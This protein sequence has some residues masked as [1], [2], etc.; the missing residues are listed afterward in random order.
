MK[1]IF[2][3]IPVVLVACGGS[4]TDSPAGTW[5]GY[6]ELDTPTNADVTKWNFT[7]ELAQPDE[8]DLYLGWERLVGT[9]DIAGGDYSAEGL[10][11]EDA[12]YSFSWCQAK[13]G[14]GDP[15]ESDF[16]LWQYGEV[17]F[18]L[19]T[20]FEESGSIDIGF[21]GSFADDSMT[22]DCAD[23]YFDNSAQYLLDG[24]FSAERG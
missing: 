18:S 22:G 11:M 5:A 17:E 14:C 9:Y 2:W 6:C 10:D 20:P 1:E 13:E 8:P 15:A 21:N 12:S 3:I 23:S 16:P 24:S 7:L 4:K 19:T